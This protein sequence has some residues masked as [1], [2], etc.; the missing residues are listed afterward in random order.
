MKEPIPP[1][2]GGFF[3]FDIILFNSIIEN[4]I[5]EPETIIDGEIYALVE[6]PPSLLHTRRQQRRMRRRAA[7][8]LLSDDPHCE[9]VERPHTDD[10]RLSRLAQA[11]RG[12]LAENLQGHAPTDA[13]RLHIAR[14]IIAL[15]WTIL[16][17]EED[18]RWLHATQTA[19][20]IAEAVTD[21]LALEQST[22]ITPQN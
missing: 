9:N 17:E 2:W 1:F 20:T 8:F 5:G 10:I 13:L 14:T 21:E 18:D 12:T 15:F 3:V 6:L 11:L 7:R 19:H 22:S 4:M 16:P